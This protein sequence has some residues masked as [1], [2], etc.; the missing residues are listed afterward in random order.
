M[1]LANRLRQLWHAVRYEAASTVPQICLTLVVYARSL[2]QALSTRSPCLAP[3]DDQSC[4]HYWSDYRAVAG[5]GSCCRAVRPWRYWNRRHFRTSDYERKVLKST[6]ATT[7][8]C[9]SVRRWILS[10]VGCVAPP[11][12]AG[13]FR[14]AAAAVEMAAMTAPRVGSRCWGTPLLGA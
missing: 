5:G 3:V 13:P 14:S 6:S 7:A 10:S 9:A 4:S 1:A 8:V 12:A 11:S 2:V